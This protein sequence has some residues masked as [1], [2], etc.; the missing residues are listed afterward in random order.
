[1]ETCHNNTSY[2][3]FI[4]SYR[5]YEEWKLGSKSKDCCHVSVLT[6][7][8]RNGNF[9][10]VIV[11]IFFVFVLTVPMRNGNISYTTSVSTILLRSY[12]TYEEWKHMAKKLV[13]ILLCVLTVPMRNGNCTSQLMIIELDW[14]LTVPMR[15]GNRWLSNLSMIRNCV[16]TVP[17][18][19]GN[20]ISVSISS[21][22][23]CVLTVPMR[24][25]NT[26]RKPAALPTI[27]G[28]LPYLWGMETTDGTR[29]MMSDRWVLTVPMRN[30]NYLSYS[31]NQHTRIRSYRTYEEW[32]QQSIETFGYVEPS[33]YRTY[34]E[35]KLPVC[36][37]VPV[38]QFS[39][40]R[41]YEEWKHAP[42]WWSNDKRN[43]SYRTYEEWKPCSFFASSSAS[44]V[45]TVPMRNGNLVTPSP[46]PAVSDRSYR[47]YEEWKLPYFYLSS[48]Q[49]LLFLP[50]LW[51]METRTWAF[52]IIGKRQFLPYL[53][54]M[55]TRYD[56]I[57]C[58]LYFSS[59]RTYEEW[60]QGWQ[61]LH[62]WWTLRVL[63]VPMRNGNLVSIVAKKA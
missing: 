45:L 20:L 62:T 48:P 28:F 25:G 23:D 9:V 57:V 18:R 36:H 56:S 44:S 22:I 49:W 15:N 10:I 17:M 13:F 21:I 32:K 31:L 4:S 55:E 29:Y 54:G 38:E 42:H 5:T 52:H 41:T 63:T 39:S 7:P 34:E 19:N 53:W 60:K 27:D 47:T 61:Y 8:M 1:M 30:G 46:L 33:S 37:T 43:S 35:W 40:Y 50:Y 16:L 58:L 11:I 51:G 26:T 3:K 24:N 2:N 12:R 14:V 59:Y 6:V